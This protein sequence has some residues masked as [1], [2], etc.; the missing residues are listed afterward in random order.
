MGE[1]RRRLAGET[2]RLDPNLE[3][4]TDADR[5]WFDARPHR[6]YRLRP[7]TIAELLPGEAVR[8][9]QHTVIVRGRTP[10]V[11]ARFRVGLPPLRLRRDTDENCRKLLDRLD[12]RG[13][14]ANGRSVRE[15]VALIRTL[16]PAE[17]AA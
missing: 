13:F 14:T 17:E 2:P 16:P 5:D 8:P 1:A 6:H 3:A 4:V 9:G 10:F 15:M 12:A 7:L 11:R